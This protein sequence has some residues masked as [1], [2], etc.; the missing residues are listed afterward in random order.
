MERKINTHG[1]RKKENVFNMCIVNKMF[2]TI[3]YFVP[4]TC[5][6]G[7]LSVIITNDYIYLLVSDND[8]VETKVNRKGIKYT[9]CEPCNM[10]I[11]ILYMCIHRVPSN[12]KIQ[13]TSPN[14]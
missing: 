2:L 11:P 8:K 3:Y 6:R 7:F 5:N 10:L 14:K 4:M 12:A 13:L 1:E 9:Y